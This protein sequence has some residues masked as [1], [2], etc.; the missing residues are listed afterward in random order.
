MGVIKWTGYVLAASLVLAVLLI[1]GALIAAIAFAV[2]IALCTAAI[3]GFIAYLIKEY[4][5][6]SSARSATSEKR[7][8]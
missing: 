6:S 5:E 1:G 4:C 8:S 7:D 3:V 2:G